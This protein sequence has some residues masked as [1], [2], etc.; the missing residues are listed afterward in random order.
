MLSILWACYKVN[1]FSWVSEAIAPLHKD[2]M[3]CSFEFSPLAEAREYNRKTRR[4]ALLKN[5]N[6]IKL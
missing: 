1:V 5:D 4:G 3:V 2:R 6:R